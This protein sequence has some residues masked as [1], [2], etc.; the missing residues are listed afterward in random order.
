[1]LVIWLGALSVLAGILVLV[2]KAVWKG[3]MSTASR[4]PTPDSHQSLEPPGPGI[5][6]FALSRNWPGLA[7]IGLGAVL[8][9]LGGAL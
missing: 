7:L 8:L 3:P 6:V 1:M 2:G 4:S 9:L 5:T